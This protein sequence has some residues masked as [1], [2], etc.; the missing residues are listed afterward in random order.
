M[1]S[2]LLDLLKTSNDR[3]LQE[4]KCQLL[5]CRGTF[6]LM[7]TLKH[8]PCKLAA[9]LLPLQAPAKQGTSHW[10]AALQQ[11]LLGLPFL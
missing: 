1:E 2:I 7:F 4:P 6:S 8:F 11:V 5:I 3:F 10:D 9:S